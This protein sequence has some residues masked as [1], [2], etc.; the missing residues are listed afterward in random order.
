VAGESLI[1]MKKG[2]K[3]LAVT[4]LS[5]HALLGKWMAWAIAN[6]H[7]YKDEGLTETTAAFL[8]NRPLKQ[9]DARAKE[10]LLHHTAG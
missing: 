4:E 5:A 8:F 10:K 6:G 2:E 7:V 1:F 3:S 9:P